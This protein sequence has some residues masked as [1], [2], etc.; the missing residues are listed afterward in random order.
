[1]R[2]ATIATAYATGAVLGGLLGLHWRPRRPLLACSVAVLALA[3]LAAGLAVPVSL[4]LLAAALLG[5]G[6]ASLGELL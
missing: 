4:P 3:P 6:Q 2:W 5:G 1:L